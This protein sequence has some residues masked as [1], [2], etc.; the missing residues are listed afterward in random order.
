MEINN[1]LHIAFQLMVITILTSPEIRMDE[2]TENIN[3]DRK[4]K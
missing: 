1:L 3:R 4:K 2:L